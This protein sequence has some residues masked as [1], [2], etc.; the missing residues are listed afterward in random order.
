MGTEWEGGR[1]QLFFRFESGMTRL[2]LLDA[3]DAFV[4]GAALTRRK[5]VLACAEP[6]VLPPV[7]EVI[8]GD[9]TLLGQ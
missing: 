8:V 5:D 4:A 7:T 2:A 6:R 3:L 1:G 9:V